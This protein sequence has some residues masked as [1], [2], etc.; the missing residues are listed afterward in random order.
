MGE[1]GSAVDA[2]LRAG[3]GGTLVVPTV[4]G[5]LGAR[6][7]TRDAVPTDVNSISGMHGDVGMGLGRC[8][9]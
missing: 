6:A 8:G 5:A 1:A 7:D 3:A 4:I 9:G 2:G